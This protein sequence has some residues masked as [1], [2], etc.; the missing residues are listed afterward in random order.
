MKVLFTLFIAIQLVFI[1]ACTSTS[2]IRDTWHSDNFHPDDFDEVLVIGQ[3]SNTST[4]LIWEST[5]SRELEK[6][7][8]KAIQ[9]NKVMGNGKISKEKVIEYIDKNPTKYVLATRIEDVKETN[10]YVQPTASVYSTG[11][12]YYPGYYGHSGF[13]GSSTMITTE[14][15]M[16]T[17]E[18]LIMETT[19]FDANYLFLRCRLSNNR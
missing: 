11:G 2:K 3:S 4:R 6:Y 1:T 13:W 10:N 19:I 15:Y 14:G 17:Y 9:S 8:V 7:G 16:D 12:Y 5:F 18:T